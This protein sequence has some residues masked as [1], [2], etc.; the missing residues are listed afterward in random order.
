MQYKNRV[1]RKYVLTKLAPG[2]YLL[3]SNDAKTLWRI[4]RY[5]DLATSDG[6]GMVGVHVWGLWR[7]GLPL[8]GAPA[9]QHWPY[10]AFID[11]D[12]SRLWEMVESN[13]QTR[14]EA[15]QEALRLGGKV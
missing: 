14:A 10:P 11:T 3:P 9:V 5:E 12:D 4:T 8:G 7:W 15:I 13:L 6:R 1:E 2:D